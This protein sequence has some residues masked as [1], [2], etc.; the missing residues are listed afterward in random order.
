MTTL[1]SAAQAYS[2]KNNLRDLPNDI[3]RLRKLDNIC[4]V[5]RLCYKVSKAILKD[6]I[7]DS[8]VITLKT[9][10]S[11][12]LNDKRILDSA[13]IALREAYG[14]I[15]L[16]RENLTVTIYWRNGI[17]PNLRTQEHLNAK[18][19][20]AVVGNKNEKVQELL[21]KKADPTVPGPFG[22]TAINAVHNNG[23]LKDLLNL[24]KDKS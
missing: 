1:V 11:D 10:H 15:E 17:A 23:E 16:K 22:I 3:S 2:T 21:L 9:K 12:W 19:F 20:Q 8:V 13:A 14:D 18:L 7:S 24:Y 4:G 6:P 5:E